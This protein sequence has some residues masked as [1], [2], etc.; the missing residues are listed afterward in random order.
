M[1]YEGQRG[2]EVKPHSVIFKCFQVTLLRFAVGNAFPVNMCPVS[3]T[4]QV[5]VKEM[6]HKKRP[7]SASENAAV[8][9]S[10]EAEV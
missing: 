2:D 1:R 10:T 6:R 5:A 3:P 4:A 9:F 7:W 8:K